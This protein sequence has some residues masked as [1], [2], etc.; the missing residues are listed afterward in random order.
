MENRDGV[1]VLGGL[2]QATGTAE[3]EIALAMIDRRG[4]TKRITLGAG[5]GLSRKFVH[6]L[7][8]RSVTPHFAVDGH[9]SKTGK[10]RKTAID[11]RTTRHSG[12]DVSVAA[13]ASKKSSAGS[14]VLLVWPRSSCEAA[15]GWTASSSW[16]FRPTI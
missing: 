3:R 8:N 9:L 6:D 14:R 7:R 4:C 10:W 15:T 16:R 5:Q 12:Y 2:S 13:G 1:A 11:A